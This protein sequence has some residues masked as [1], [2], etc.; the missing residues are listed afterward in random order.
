[1]GRFRR[2]TIFG[3]TIA[4]VAVVACNGLTGIGDLSVSSTAGDAGPDTSPADVFTPP[5]NDGGNDEGSVTPVDAGPPPLCPSAGN[6]CVQAA[7]SGWDGPFLLYSGDR[8]SAPDC[9]AIMPSNDDE[10][11]GDPQ[12]S[13]TCADCKCGTP[14][15]QTCGFTM[16]E[17]IDPNC[18]APEAADV[19]PTMCQT[20]DPDAGSG[21]VT[22]T[23]SLNGG[24]C[25]KSVGTKTPS[26]ITWPNVARLCGRAGDFLSDGCPDGSLCVPDGVQPYLQHTCIRQMHADVDCPSGGP[27]TQKTTTFNNASD[28]RDCTTDG[29][30]CDGP[31]GGTCTGSLH[32]YTASTTCG[33]GFTTVKVPTTACTTGAPG[34]SAKIFGNATSITNTGSCNGGIG[35]GTPTAV[36]GVGGGDD[37]N[38]ICCVP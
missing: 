6:S 31:S 3:F 4:C 10:N 32:I 5:A 29:C 27:W 25:D 18:T 24:F 13:I 22:V 7:P 34:E 36:G 9:P 15:N 17:Y 38:T 2:A 33:G 26:D 37:V 19:D 11:V 8:N 20:A 35:D 28:N 14:K 16:Q 21:S 12:G 30:S 23:T 1:M